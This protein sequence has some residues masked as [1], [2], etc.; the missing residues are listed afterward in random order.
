MFKSLGTICTI[1]FAIL[2][3]ALEPIDWSKAATVQT[4]VKHVR[5]ET[6]TPRLMKINILRIDLKTPGLEFTAT[7]KAPGWGTPMPD[8]PTRIIR[9][10]RQRTRVFMN[11]ARKAGI[12]MI[13]AVNASPWGPWEKPFNH[14]FA[15]PPGVHILDG[16]V[17]SDNGKKR[18]TFVIYKDG[19]PAIVNGIPKEDYEKIKLSVSGFSIVAQDGKILYVDEQLHPRTLYGIS[20]DK[21]YVYLMTIDG[22]QKDWS[23]GAACSDG[24][25]ILVAAGASDVINMDGGGSSTLIYWDEKENKIVSLCRHNKNGS[26]RTVG[27]NMGIILKQ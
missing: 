22:R 3:A 23:L 24:G 6:D 1:F 7:G 18:P 11:E 8:Y 17:I 16:E 15:E 13:V 4:G 19:S 14:K 9:T 21:R 12:N 26:E 27:N 2:A 25:K 5:I 10:K 20:K